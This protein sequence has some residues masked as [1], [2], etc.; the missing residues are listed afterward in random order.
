VRGRLHRDVVERGTRTPGCFSAI[1]RPPATACAPARKP[2]RRGAADGRSIARL[3]GKDDMGIRYVLLSERMGH[4]VQGMRGV[5]SHITHGMRAEL[6]SRAPGAVGRGLEGTCPSW[7]RRRLWPR[8]TTSFWCTARPPPSRA[9]SR[10]APKPFPES[11]TRPAAR[12]AGIARQ[13]S[14]LRFYRGERWDSNPRHPG[15]QPGALTN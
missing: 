9:R 8:S 14:G 4:E 13:R 7:R 3:A 11:D 6:K 12:A 10:S 15:P 5:C 2:K 1:S